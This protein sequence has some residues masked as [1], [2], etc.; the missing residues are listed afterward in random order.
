MPGNVN[1]AGFYRGWDPARTTNNKESRSTRL[2]AA[3]P[4]PPRLAPSA[5]A[6]TPRN[7]QHDATGWPPFVG[8]R[9]QSAPAHDVVRILRPAGLR[10]Q[11][12]CR[13]GRSRISLAP[14]A[15]GTML[16]RVVPDGAVQ[17]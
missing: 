8:A 16:R 2:P 14:A 5:R 4:R 6:L 15:D 7:T 9:L 3:K 17:R 13:S 1:R 10:R 11:A 12:D